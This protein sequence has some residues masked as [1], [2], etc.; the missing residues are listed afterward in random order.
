MKLYAYCIKDVFSSQDDV[1]LRGQ[2]CMPSTCVHNKDSWC[3]G[4]E[5]FTN[6]CT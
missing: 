4:N 3:D 1:M 2:L 6:A 5:P